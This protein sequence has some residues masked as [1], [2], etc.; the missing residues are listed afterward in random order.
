MQTKILDG[1]SSASC[2]IDCPKKYPKGKTP[3]II[4]LLKEKQLEAFPKWV[5]VIIAQ[6][7]KMETT[8][9]RKS[10]SHR[11]AVERGM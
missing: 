3:V 9:C 2:I 7:E 5:Q 10:I 11:N 4:N 6:R 1:F 8:N